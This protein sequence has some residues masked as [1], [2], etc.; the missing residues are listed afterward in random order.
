M[1]TFLLGA[2]PCLLL[3]QVPPLTYDDIL[4]RARTSPEQ[5]RTE[6]L[7]A[8]RHRALSGTRGFLR[9]GPALGVAAGP[10]THPLG[11]ATTDQSVELD[12]PLFLSPGTRRRLEASLGQADLALREAARTEARFH[13][14]RAY[15]EAWLGERLLQL[16][17][18]DVATVSSWLQAARARLEAGADPGFQV[19]LVE[20]EALRAE[21][22][23]DEARRQRLNAWAGLRAV[24]EVPGTPVPLADPGAPLLPH[25]EGLAAKFEASTLRKALQSRLDLEEQALRHQEAVATSRWSLRG[26]YAREGEERVG[27]VG[28]AYRFSRPGEGQAL[29][30][31]TEANLQATTR[32]LEVALLELDAR[33]QS[34]LI[35]LQTA[36]PPLPF[37]GFDLSLNAVSLRLSEGKERPSEALPIRR[38]LLEAQ[39]ASH[40]HLQAAHL[41]AAELQALTAEVN[42]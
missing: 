14:R 31:E 13:L 36:T 35:R 20:G 15:L 19:S 2:L 32:E 37:K 26:S 7:L 24:A 8:E 41:L 25:V 21:A 27:K 9:E 22:D 6:A 38:Q 29:R 23:L 40:R 18:A 34:A 12:L 39:A 1:R 30:R 42:P 3:A 11:P 4:P 28:L 5:Y 33:F 17:E 10:R 16:R